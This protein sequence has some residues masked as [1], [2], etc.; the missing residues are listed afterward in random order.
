M[1][2]FVLLKRYQILFIY[3]ENPITHGYYC[4][5]S[6]CIPN[7]STSRSQYSENLGLSSVFEPIYFESPII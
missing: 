4:I 1:I 3:P 7:D 5:C 2:I 6:S